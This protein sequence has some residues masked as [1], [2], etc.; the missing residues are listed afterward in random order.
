M[1]FWLILLRP[2]TH[3]IKSRDSYCLF[4]WLIT[5]NLLNSENSR[6]GRKRRD[7]HTNSE[8]GRRIIALATFKCSPNTALLSPNVATS[9]KS[10]N[11]LFKEAGET[12]CSTKQK[13]QKAFKTCQKRN[14]PQ[15][16]TPLVLH[17]IFGKVMQSRVCK[18]TTSAVNSERLEGGGNTCQSL[19][20]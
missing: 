17:L 13:V 9:A 15:S 1:K 4:S 2:S 11:L 18:F 12:F 8:N 14:C 16:N 7:K 10:V 19:Y 3:L 6:L 5:L 20:C